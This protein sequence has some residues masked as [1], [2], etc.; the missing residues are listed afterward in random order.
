MSAI[1]NPTPAGAGGSANIKTT[2]ID[3]GAVPTNYGIFSI[4]DADVSAGSNIGIW[5]SM[6]APTGRDADEAEVEPMVC[7]ATNMAS[8]TFDAVVQV[9]DG[10]VEGKY[11][12]NHLVG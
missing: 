10:P 8:G 7:Q 2:E 4:A 1:V 11:K 6:E 12:L 5:L 3:F 9:H